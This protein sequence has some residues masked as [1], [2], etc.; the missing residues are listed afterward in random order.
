MRL[1][2]SKGGRIRQHQAFSQSCVLA[3]DD[4]EFEVERMRLCWQ[5]VTEVEV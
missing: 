3:D 1:Y 5:F 2:K 4:V